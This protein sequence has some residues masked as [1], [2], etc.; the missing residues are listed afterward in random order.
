VV[1]SHR[2]V[3]EMT[4]VILNRINRFIV[5]G[6]AA[7]GTEALRL[8]RRHKPQLVITSLSLAEI[9]GPEMLHTMRAESPG[10]LTMLYPATT[11]LSLLYAGLDTG[12]QGFVHKSEPLATFCQALAA[13]AQGGTFFSPFTTG[14]LAERRTSLAGKE[15]LSP[16]ERTIVQ[17]IAE[18]ASSKELASQLNL[19][20]KSVEHYRKSIMRKLELNSIASL[21]LYAV[22][23]GMVHP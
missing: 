10:T 22:R 13:V 20:A 8:F 23:N 1:D 19:S 21:T 17:L 12:P 7:S 5:A 3:A 9:S 18:G 14:L 4:S 2:S 11:N 16:R 15:R 6:E